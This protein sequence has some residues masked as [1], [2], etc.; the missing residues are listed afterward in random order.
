MEIQPS[1][2]QVDAC[3]NHASIQ[4]PLQHLHAV[5]GG[6]QGADQLGACTETENEVG[7]GTEAEPY[8]SSLHVLAPRRCSMSGGGQNTLVKAPAASVDGVMTAFRSRSWKKCCFALARLL[9]TMV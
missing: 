6:T 2:G 4:H 7:V 8:S 5:A 1:P 9:L 3:A